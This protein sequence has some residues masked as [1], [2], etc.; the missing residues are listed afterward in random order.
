MVYSPSEVTLKV[1]DG[2]EVTITEDTVYPMGDEIRFEISMSGRRGES[3]PFL[4]RRPGWCDEPEV[5]VNGEIFHTD[6][7]DD[8][9]EIDREWKDGDI[10]VLRLPMKVAISRWHENSVAVERGPLVYALPLAEQWE[11]KSLSG[12]DAVQF[13]P[14]YYEVT[15]DDR[16]NYGL[17]E[18]IV[19]NPAFCTV[20]IDESKAA[21]SFFW[22]MESAPVKII[23]RAKEHPYWEKYGPDA[24]PLPFS[25]QT[26]PYPEEEIE[27]IPY[28]C[29]TLRISEFPVVW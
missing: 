7:D 6:S 27:L 13:G 2:R 21:E 15:S 28:G 12:N 5:S 16:W 18:T 11:K 4:L 25:I 8:M 14:E 24:G 22:N 1:G 3:F 26:S 19:K 23:V 29:T 9:I 20:Q 17:V 10:V